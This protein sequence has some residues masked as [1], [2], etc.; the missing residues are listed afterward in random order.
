RFKGRAPR[1]HVAGNSTEGNMAQSNGGNR[2]EYDIDNEYEQESGSAKTSASPPA[3]AV[4]PKPSTD[5]FRP[6]NL[7][8]AGIYVPTLGGRR[9]DR[10]DAEDH[11]R[12]LQV[13]T[14]VA[15]AAGG[16]EQELTRLIETGQQREMA[17]Q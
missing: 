15:G 11:I 6:R 1:V 12:G 13:A 10:R 16:F 17:E 2:S 9:R 5:A 4:V 8:T 7:P 14:R 3:P